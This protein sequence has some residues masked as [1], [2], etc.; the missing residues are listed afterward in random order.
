MVMHN[1]LLIGNPNIGKTS[2]FNLLTGSRQKTSNFPGTTVDYQLATHKSE[3]GTIRLVDLPGIYSLNAQLPVE[4]IVSEALQGH[5][6]GEEPNYLL[7]VA[8]ITRP[9]TGLRLALEAKDLGLSFGVV[10]T[11]ADRATEAQ[12]ANFNR[13]VSQLDVP[14]VAVSSLNLQ[15][16]GRVHALIESLKDAVAPVDPEFKTRYSSWKSQLAA[17][18]KGYQT[19]LAEARNSLEVDT[20]TVNEDAKRRDRLDRIFLH[21]VWGTIILITIF[22]AMFTV[23]FR[24]AEFPM[25]W[26]EWGFGWLGDQVTALIGPGALSSLLADGI[27]AGVGAV[28][29]FLPQIILLFLIIAILEETG[30]LARSAALLDRFL[31]PVG[32]SGHSFVPLLSCFACA[33][34]G[35][36]ATRN[37]SDPRQ[38]FVTI[39]IA[40]LM[41]CSARWPI[42]TLF[43]SAF[44]PSQTVLGVFSLQALVMLGLV[45][46]GFLSAL[47]IAF[48]FRLL[49]KRTYKPGF[50]L[51]LPP[52]RQPI[53]R[54]VWLT[55]WTKVGDFLKTA[56]TL[57]MLFAVLVWLLGYYPNPPTPVDEEG[58]PLVEIVAEPGEDAPRL[59]TEDESL[60]SSFLGVASSAVQPIFEP[61]G[62][63]WRMTVSILT[64]FAA[65]EVAVASMGVIYSLDPEDEAEQ[66]A[67]QAKLAQ[68]YSLA[69]AL[70]FLVFF[71]YALQCLSTVAVVKRETRSWLWPSLQFVYMTLLAYGMAVLTF[72]ITLAATGAG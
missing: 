58:K 7:I 12:S 42:Y 24:M 67:L 52:Y 41:T 34:P 25:T 8:D 35:I 33:I 28:L 23:I 61:M 37:M 60:E 64:A 68:D 70:A 56:G 59:V 66:V 19:K 10:A 72:Q 2:L 13:I 22:L 18:H 51:E 14:C 47:A 65:R 46:L 38:R 31:K 57:I 26:I 1:V 71:V 15:D 48:V 40:P 63:D 21:P 69:A 16:R 54:N 17:D 11:M 32:L 36:M 5:P 50:L 55:L 44:I 62:A 9:E 29:V 53:L 49:L 30:Y 3:A 6:W 43:V 20:Q 27:I 39:M 4:E 45:M